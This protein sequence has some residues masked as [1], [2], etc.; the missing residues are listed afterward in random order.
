MS[1]VRMWR[2]WRKAP[3]WNENPIRIRPEQREETVRNAT[4]DTGATRKRA[5][6]PKKKPQ[7][8]TEGGK[9]VVRPVP[10]WITPADPRWFKDDIQVW[11]ACHA[12]EDNWDDDD[13]VKTGIDYAFAG[14]IACTFLKSDRHTTSVTVYVGDGQ[15]GK[16]MRLLLYDSRFVYLNSCIYYKGSNGKMYP[17]LIVE[18]RQYGQNFNP[19]ATLYW[20][21]ATE[22]RVLNPQYNLEMKSLYWSQ[23]PKTDGVREVD[24]D[25]IDF[26]ARFIKRRGLKV[27]RAD[28]PHVDDEFLTAFITEYPESRR[29]FRKIG[30]WPAGME[31][32]RRWW[33]AA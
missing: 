30:L 2:K 13:Y 6:R 8:I 22:F 11:R 17:I 23:R 16:A 10:E 15:T 32:K 18:P 31:K 1:L 28:I 14:G 25:D 12:I 27:D 20:W 21:W 24:A 3:A 5:P 29:V 7:V 33:E 19:D 26:L 9:R 4:R